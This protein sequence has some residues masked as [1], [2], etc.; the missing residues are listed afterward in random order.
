[1]NKNKVTLLIITNI[2]FSLAT[3][4]GLCVIA[5]YSISTRLTILK[6]ILNLIYYIGFIFLFVTSSNKHSCLNII[7]QNI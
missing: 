7:T 2:I 5:A 3:Y 4:L 6:A 1:M